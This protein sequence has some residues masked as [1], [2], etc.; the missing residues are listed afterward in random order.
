MYFPF[1][2]YLFKRFL[3]IFYNFF[4]QFRF[5]FVTCSHLFVF[6]FGILADDTPPVGLAAYAGAAIAGSDP[7][8]TGIQG[9]TYDMR[10]AILPF[11]FI[12]NTQLL[13]ISGVAENGD[14]I[15]LNNV[16]VLAWVFFVSLIAIF[17]FASFMQG[18]FADDCNWPERLLLLVLSILM[19]RPTL[20]VG[21]DAG[22]LRELIQAVAVVLYFAL[23]FYQKRR[24]KLRE[25]GAPAAQ[26]G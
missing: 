5:R 13:M 4:L 9:F 19:F 12:F 15:W 16:F 10:T 11:V 2:E 18:Y 7:I 23:Y 14:I 25:P 24:R 8:K 22:I 17:A 20:V 3:Y 6:Y 1:G 21:D 26:A